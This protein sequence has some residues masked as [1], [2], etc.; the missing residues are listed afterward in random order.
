MLKKSV[1][2]CSLVM[3]CA[4]GSQALTLRGAVTN[5]STDAPV[6]GAIVTL[7]MGANVYTDTSIGGGA[8]ELITRNN[9]TTSGLLL[10][11]ATGYNLNNQFVTGLNV[12]DTVNVALTP[13]GNTTTGTKKIVGTVTVASGTNAGNA[14]DSVL[15]I[16][17]TATGR[18][19]DTVHSGS[20]GKYV[21]DS[22]SAGTYDITATKL[23][24]TQG[25]AAVRLTTAMDSIVSNIA[26]IPVATGTLTG[27]VVKA[28]DTA[29]GIAAKVVLTR[30]VNIGGVVTTTRID[31]ITAAASGVYTLD[32][33]PVNT[34]YRLLVTA[35]G[36][37]DAQSPNTFTLVTNQT[38]TENFRLLAVIPPSGIVNGTVTNSVD[39][40]AVGQA[41]VILRRLNNVNYTPID[42]TTTLANGSF[43]FTGLAIGTY[44]IV[45]SKTDYTTYTTPLN[46]A[47]NLTTNP[48]TATVAVSLVPVPKGNLIVFVHD[49][50]NAAVPGASV[51]AVQA[52]LGQTYNG[53]TATNG[54]VKFAS[55]STGSYN[56]TISAAGFNTQTS[57]GNTVLANANDTVRITLAAAT[58]AAKVVKGTV[59]TSGGTGIGSAVVVLTARLNTNVLTLVDTCGSDGSYLIA[60]IP[61]GY[62]TAALSV[63][64][65]SY[66]TKDTSGISIANDTTTVNVTL[67]GIVGVSVARSHAKT[68]LSF[69]QSRNGI[70]LQMGDANIPARV[71]LYSTNGRLVLSRTVSQSGSALLIPKKWSN[72]VML[73]TIQQGNTILRQKVT[74]R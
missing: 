60:G 67:A 4:V 11:T 10:V 33:I 3:I 32:N 30:T 42:T 12:V 55:V 43:A 61:V 24:Y 48:D 2:L 19:L 6:V 73:L 5:A 20:N 65:S 13:T 53:I 47:L 15:M 25:A 68:G 39:D 56:L 21:F 41:T 70:Y 54:Y 7:T 62:T 34:G 72:Q 66:L 74:I 49:N 31:S 57:A 28:A 40:N 45:V 18:P 58:G 52:V 14:I 36:Y 46:R 22:L 23:G 1:L 17:S 16:L 44:S 71:M 59:K 26:L 69:M 8:Y 37:A 51:S 27:K 50:V 64:K 63:S 35:T 9:T 38:R 29:T